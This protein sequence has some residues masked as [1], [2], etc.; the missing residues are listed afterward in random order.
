MLSGV[1]DF[2]GIGRKTVEKE[3][4]NNITHFEVGN[5]V[6]IKNITGESFHCKRFNFNT[7]VKSNRVVALNGTQIVELAITPFKAGFG[8][9]LEVYSLEGLCKIKYNRASVGLVTL[10]FNSQH[11][12]QYIVVE[13]SKFIELLRSQMQ[14]LGLKGDVMKNSIDAKHIETATSF[15]KATK[16]IEVGF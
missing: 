5:E 7:G 3:I 6:L 14:E 2:A 11:I 10:T 15:F 12:V 8:I 16:E 1:L 9:V 4:L 13:S